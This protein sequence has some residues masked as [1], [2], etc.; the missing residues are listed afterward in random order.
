MKSA[1]N[2]YIL[3]FI[4]ILAFVSC[5]PRRVQDPTSSGEE[6]A[7]NTEEESFSGDD[8][9]IPYALLVSPENPQSGESFRVMAVGGKGIRKAKIEIEGPSSSGNSGHTRQGDGLPFWRVEQFEAGAT[10]QYRAKLIVNRQEV[11][12]QEFS[13]LA[14]KI[15]AKSSGSIWRTERGWDGQYEALYSAWVNALFISAGE[16][17][18]WPA[19]HEVT[20]DPERNILHNYLGWGEDDAA[21]K[22]RVIM[23]PDCADNPFYFR[24]YFAWKLGLPFGYHE[25]DRGWL[26]K[27][28]ST[29][30]WITNETPTSRS[31]PVLSFNAFLRRLMDGVHSGTARAA[32]S[33]D[34]ADYYPVPLTR[35]A[36]RPGVTFADPYGHTLILVKWVPQSGNKPGMLL[37]WPSSASGKGTSSLPPPTS[38]ANPASKHSAPLPSMPRGCI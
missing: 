36:L 27:A 13:V 15:P 30:R 28:P 7:V 31:H 19:L 2:P 16:G 26:G 33:N 8:S 37:S 9:G 21:G 29:G 6:T 12:S 38:S 17:D 18:S 34:N 10:G 11:S 20:Q 14:E 24:A 3:L 4:L 1:R 5:N 22:T 25:S 32:F 35:E 23:E